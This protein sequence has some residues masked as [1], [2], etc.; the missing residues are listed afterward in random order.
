M[1]SDQ[2]PETSSPVF[3]QPAPTR[4][5]RDVLMEKAL[6]RV[7]AL[8][9]AT[10]A[11][12]AIFLWGWVVGGG[13]TATIGAVPSDAVVGFA[14]GADCPRGWSVYDAAVSRTIVGSYPPKWSGQR[15]TDEKGLLL[16]P[17][18]IYTTAGE[19]RH[20]LTE[21]ELP[22]HR[23]NIQRSR[24]TSGDAAYVDWRN[25]GSESPITEGGKTSNAGGSEAHNNMPPYVALLFCKKD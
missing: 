5:W 2:A 6:D 20:T 8:A 4:S 14:T 19:E 10:I 11:G 18:N 9:G 24:G 17:R 15:N 23:H 12:I 21:P 13:L 25:M 22:V 16:T 1:T 3:T 7:V